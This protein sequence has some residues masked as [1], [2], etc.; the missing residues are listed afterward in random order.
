MQGNKWLRTMTMLVAL[1]KAG[2]MID[3]LRISVSLRG[4]IVKTSSG[5]TYSSSTLPYVVIA[6]DSAKD[7]FAKVKNLFPFLG[8]TGATPEGLAYEAILDDVINKKPDE[9]Y[10]FLNISD[11]EPCFSYNGPGDIRINYDQNIGAE[12]TR[13]Q[14][15]KII[16]SGVKGI[17][18]FIEDEY[19]T[20]NPSIENQGVKCFKRMYSKD[21]RFINVNS[22]A[23][24]AKTMN[25]LFLNKE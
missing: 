10:Y 7:K 4:T 19:Y 20:S 18:Y 8:P 15:T 22:V 16:Q 9:E 2:S 14:Y 13:K 21:A 5:N 12:H 23:A 17:S 6:Y 11:G 1:C 25:Q 3:N 24:I